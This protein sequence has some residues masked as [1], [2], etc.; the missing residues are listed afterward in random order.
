MTI[1]D[2]H[3]SKIKIFKI[4]AGP[5]ENNSYLV[6]CNK[7]NHSVLI[8]AP[9]DANEII[10]L[11]QTTQLQMIIITHGHLDHIAGLNQIQS[12]INVPVAISKSDSEQLKLVNYINNIPNIYLE[13]NTNIKV[14]NTS[15]KII[16]TPGHTPGSICIN[17]EKHLF[18]GDTLFPGGPGKTTSVKNFKQIVASITS[19][20]FILPINTVIYPGHGDKDILENSIKEYKIFNTLNK[21][22]D[23]FGDIVWK[24]NIIN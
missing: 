20:L 7:T 1:P 17:T 23:I 24:N 6:V 3:D 2:Y 14:G 12:Y 19:K 5:Y 15:L 9:S 4:I 11:G 22:K 10:K 8:D 13:D 21:G 18:T 16:K